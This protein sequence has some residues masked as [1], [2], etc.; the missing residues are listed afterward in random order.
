[1]IGLSGEPRCVAVSTDGKIYV[2]VGDH[3]EIFDMAGQ[4]LAS[5]EGLGERAFLT[6]IA[7]SKDDIFVA[8][9]GNSV[10]LRYDTAGEVVNRI[11]EKDPERNVPGFHVPSPY[12]DLAVASDGLLRV[13]SPDRLRIEAY[14]FDGDLEFWWG[15]N[16]MRIEGFCGCCNPVNFAM[17]PDGGYVTAEKGLIR[18][19]VHEPDGSFKGVVAGPEQLVEGGAARVFESVDDAQASGFDVAVDADGRVHVLDTIENA[20]RVFAKNGKGGTE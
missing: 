18:V 4:R 8:D 1:V 6:S 17:L 2:G 9:A 13:V 3:L 7:V 5:W 12:F 19:K 11:G 16:S 14:T 20:V 15:R 10:V